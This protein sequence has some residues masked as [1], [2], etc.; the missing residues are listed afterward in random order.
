VE[1]GF[2]FMFGEGEALAKHKI[3]PQ[4]TANPKEPG[5]ILYEGFEHAVICSFW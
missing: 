4:I 1:K 2:Y 5:I 3:K